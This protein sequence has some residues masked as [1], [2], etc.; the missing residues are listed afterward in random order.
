[1]KGKREKN[2]KMRRGRGRRIK[3][4]GVEDEDGE[5]GEE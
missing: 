3:R 4:C 2:I 5:E 1:M